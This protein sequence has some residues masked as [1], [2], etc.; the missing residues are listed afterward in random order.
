VECG[1][2]SYT[3]LSQKTQNYAWGGCGEPKEF[4]GVGSEPVAAIFFQF[5]RQV[6]DGDGFEWT[7]SH[8]DTAS[9]AE[10]FHDLR[11]VAFEY[12]GFNLVSHW[13]TEA[14]AWSTATFGVASFLVE[15]R[16]PNHLSSIHPLM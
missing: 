6:D 15:N 4:E 10:A 8:A 16:Y 1:G 2:F 12:D 13:R 5:I 3:I 14:I 11:L 7:F 9:Y